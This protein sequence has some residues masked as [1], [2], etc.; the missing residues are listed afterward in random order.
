MNYKK[1]VLV[2]R[3]TAPGGLVE[4]FN[5]RAQ[6]QFTLSIAAAI[7]RSTSASMRRITPRWAQLRQGLAGFGED[8]GHRARVLAQ[9]PVCRNRP[10]VT[11]GI[12][13]LVVNTAKYSAG[14]RW[15]RSTPTRSTLTAFSCRFTVKKG[16]TAVRAALPRQVRVREVTM[17]EARLNDG[18][19]LLAFNDLFIGV[20]SHTSAR[21]RI[22]VGSERS[23]SSSSG[24]IVSDGGGR[25]RLVAA[26]STWRGGWCRASRRRPAVS[27][28]ALRLPWDTDRLIYVV[29]EPFVSKTSGA[30]FVCGAITG[31]A[32]CCSNPRRPKV[33]LSSATARRSRLPGPSTRA[34]WRRLAWPRSAPGW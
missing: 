25:H 18:Q 10:V 32:R 29:R 23:I 14:S 28:D 17:A 11:I 20:R 12:D 24:I 34:R 7:L 1:I 9:F 30:S 33:A 2:T 13:G 21:Y 26:C 16:L 8:A 6:A 31:D 15:W 19:R 5:T 4:R 27:L 22:A 3:K